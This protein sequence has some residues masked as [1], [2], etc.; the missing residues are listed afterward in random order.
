MRLITLTTDFGYGDWFVGAMKGVILSIEP[1]ATVVDITHAIPPGDVSAAA[2]ALAACWRWFPPNAIHIAV[3][4]PG[5]GSSRKAI[6]IRSGATTFLAP[7][8]GL[9]SLALADCK[10]SAIRSLE[11]PRFFSGPLSHTF[12]A[13][14]VFAPCAAHLSR[15]ASFSKLGP[16]LRD[17]HQ[18]HWPEPQQRREGL[19]G[20]IIYLDRFGNAITNLPGDLVSK[21]GK[22]ARVVVGRKASFPVREFYQSVPAGRAVAV[23]GSSGFLE[24]AVNGGNASTKYR[25]RVGD[26]VTLC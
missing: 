22:V 12:H 6:A 15:G 20:E 13:R 19:D 24:L 8:N 23:P 9:L 5:V 26:K 14:D 3:V 10:T 25:L 4:D 2:F 16:A 11:N 7:D 1:R 18:L 21:P 17:F